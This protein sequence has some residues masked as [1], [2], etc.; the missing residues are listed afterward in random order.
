MELLEAS[1]PHRTAFVQRHRGQ[2]WS[3]AV[4]PDG[5]LIATG[6]EDKT[7]RLWETESGREVWTIPGYVDSVWSVAFRPNGMHIA[8]ASGARRKLDHV[9]IHEVE[10]GKAVAFPI[11]KGSGQLSSVEFSAD[12]GRL[13]I[14]G[15][16]I[17]SGSWVAVYDARTG[18]ESLLIPLGPDPVYSASLSPDGTS[19]M[20]VVGSSN[21]ADFA[22][23]AN[24]V[25]VWDAKTKTLRF[26][27]HGDM[28]PILKTC[29]S[30]D[31]AKIATADYDATI[32]IW[33]AKNGLELRISRSSKL[34]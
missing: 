15:G 12:G 5:R 32:K 23:K 13:V 26:T 16:E 18:L 31:G 34:R 1:M 33:N 10:T 14:A 3:L 29:F 7:L 24:E 8:S 6:G 28:K 27:L 4:S 11:T 20:A 21:P 30:L 22:G 2:I 25:R 17:E 19:L 9:R